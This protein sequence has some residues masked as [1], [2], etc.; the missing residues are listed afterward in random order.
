MA[1]TLQTRENGIN[2]TYTSL[3]TPVRPWAHGVA[4]VI[5]ASIS[6]ALFYP[7][8]FLRTRMHVYKGGNKFPLRSA[9]QIIREEGL[10]AMYNGITMSIFAHSVGWGLYLLTFRAAQQKLFLAAEETAC[11]SDGYRSSGRHTLQDFLSACVAAVTTGV[12]ITP[13]NVLK[14]RRQL[15][16]VKSYGEPRGFVCG[17]RAILKREGFFSLLRGVGPQILLTGS[18][19]IQVTLYEG[20]KRGAFHDKDNPSFIEVMIASAISKAAAS[21]LCNPIEVVRTRLQDKRHGSLKEY[22]SMRGALYAIWRSEGVLG[23]YRGLP[24]NI[25][26]VVPTTVM[27]VVLY[28]KLLLAISSANSVKV[29]LPVIL[30]TFDSAS[31]SWVE[32]TPRD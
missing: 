14:T 31:N 1:A 26:R 28:E 25:C 24:V 11:S 32:T 12:V 23:L 3:H 16:D 2:A 29:D 9:R 15:Y 7:L 10:R 27:T 5:G 18:T 20:I 13:L 17:T 19:T 6:M 22:R 8:D 30:L 21:I 4:G